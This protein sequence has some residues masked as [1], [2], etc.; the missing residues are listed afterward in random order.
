[1][2]I[3]RNFKCSACGECC[4][5]ISHVLPEYD[6]GN[7]TCCWLDQSTNLCRIYQKRPLIC[8]VKEYW[9]QILRPEGISWEDWCRENYKA[10]ARMKKKTN[11]IQAILSISEGLDKNKDYGDDKVSI[12]WQ[13]NPGR[14]CVNIGDFE[15]GTLTEQYL[16]QLPEDKVMEIWERLNKKDQT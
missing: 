15:F 1:M 6:I 9:Q 11:I 12:T 5:H 13:P 7:G 8:R 2:Q 14:W 10:C 16:T 3:I 4:R